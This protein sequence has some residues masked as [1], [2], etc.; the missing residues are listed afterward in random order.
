MFRIAYI[1]ET[2]MSV[3]SN[4]IQSGSIST[5]NNRHTITLTVE[6]DGESSQIYYIVISCPDLQIE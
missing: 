5:N 4:L 3:F 2:N 1:E 6:G